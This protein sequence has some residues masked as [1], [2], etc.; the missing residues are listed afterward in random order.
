[1]I[2]LVDVAACPTAV[3]ET[4]V[5]RSDLAV[6]IRRSLD[7]VW[8]VVRS[9]ALV[10]GHN[11]VLYRGDLD[12]AD[13]ATVEVGVQVDRTFTAVGAVHSSASPAARVV[14]AVHRGPY[15]R[16]GDTY[17]AVARWCRDHGHRLGGVSWE[18]YG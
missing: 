5:R 2:E 12:S 15:D 16:L 18:I 3:I 7:E 9:Q 14:R 10:S 13:G 1:M 4:R 11:I 6:V 8:P 17:D